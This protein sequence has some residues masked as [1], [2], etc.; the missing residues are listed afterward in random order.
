MFYVYILSC[1]LIIIF[2]LQYFSHN[3]SY[4]T[5]WADLPTDFAKVTA[6]RNEDSLNEDRICVN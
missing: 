4:E 2:F 5:R 3:K 6:P 1:V